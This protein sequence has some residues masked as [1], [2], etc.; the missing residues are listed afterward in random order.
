MNQ[1]L[2]YWVSA[3]EIGSALAVVVTLAILIYSIRENTNLT[4]V[5]IYAD[6]MA[7][8]NEQTRDVYRDPSLIPII[9]SWLAEDVSSLEFTDRKRLE[10]TIQYMFRTYETA[11]LAFDAGFYGEVE[12]E[13]MERQACWQFDRATAA[14]FLEMLQQ[15]TTVPFY[16]HLSAACPEA[17]E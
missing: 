12:W 6:H 10:Y 3:A 17:A 5:S 8:F 13:R 7:S 2:S 15:I 11:Y 14:G 16:Q 9:E 1:R 4:R